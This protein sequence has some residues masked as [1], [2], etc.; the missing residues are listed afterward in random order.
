V[1]AAGEMAAIEMR[2]GLAGAEGELPPQPA[3]QAQASVNERAASAD[4][5]AGA[6]GRI[7]VCANAAPPGA[8]TGGCIASGGPSTGGRLYNPPMSTETRLANR[9]FLLL[10]QGQAVSQ[11]GN[12]ASAVAMAFWMLEATGSASLMGLL[13]VAQVLPMTL[14]API[15]GAVADRF[16][17]LRILILSDAVAG[18]AMLVQAVAMLSGRC[19]RPALVAMLFAVALITGVVNAFFLPALS[20]SI[21]DLVPAGRLDA[22][23]SLNQFSVQAAALIGQGLGGVLYRLLGAP[24]LFLFDGLSFLFAAGSEALVRLPPRPPTERL[25]FAASMRQFTASIGEGL[26][27][28]RR[29][30]G[31]LGFMIAPASYNFFAMAMFVLF[32]FYVRTNLHAGVE[33]YGFLIATISGGSIAGFLIAGL[34]RWRG[35]ARARFLVALFCVAP[36][37]MVA[38]AG[39][40]QKVAGLAIGFAL[41]IMVGL[42]NVNLATLLQAT[43]PA[44]LRGRVLG[45]WTSLASALMP[46]GMLAGGFAGDLTGK[47]ISLIYTTCGL[48]ALVI[49]CS[50]VGRRSTRSFLAQA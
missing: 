4:T 44:E 38:A 6:A 10:W 49:I 46:L 41:G 37:P 17:R 14:L 15:G 9:N 39:I 42:I 48:L 34:T 32:P 47:N 45:L 33:W 43:T 5:T 21:P 36:L 35:A 1:P 29:T 26:S 16:S 40:H 20:A 25:A 19:S 11:L 7:M 12:Q 8:A 22:A 30:P 18:L 27:Y 24:R 23:N 3:V 50:A 2:S 31:L 28:V 13:L